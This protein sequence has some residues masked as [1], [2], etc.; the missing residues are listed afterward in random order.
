MARNMSLLEAHSQLL[1][2]N[3]DTFWTISKLPARK[4]S[5][6][7]RALLMSD[8]G[9]GDFPRNLL[10]LGCQRLTQ[11]MVVWFCMQHSSE[12]FPL[13]C[14]CM[15]EAKKCSVGSSRL[16]HLVQFAWRLWFRPRQCLSSPW[17]PEP[18]TSTAATASQTVISPARLTSRPKML[19]KSSNLISSLSSTVSWS[20][21]V[22]IL[23]DEDWLAWRCCQFQKH[24]KQKHPGL[25]ILQLG[26]NPL[27]ITSTW[28]WANDIKWS[29]IQIMYY[30]AW[31]TELNTSF[32]ALSCAKS[33][34]TATGWTMYGSPDFL[35]C[36]LC[37]NL[38]CAQMLPILNFIQWITSLY[39]IFILFWNQ[40]TC[41]ICGQ[42]TLQH[43]AQRAPV[44]GHR[45]ASV[46]LE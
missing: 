2:Q 43:K 34:A 38:R 12:Y 11:A 33:S 9:D 31:D 45:E 16:A 20:L 4:F 32:L 14:N 37:A 23:L 10:N 29:Q 22:H 26:S 46:D 36:P 42:E 27:I 13:L 25:D 18:V 35:F 39:S 30:K 7:S 3:V 17:A 19:S 5:A 1:R 6:C 28:T 41:C 8:L 21:M 24:E 15:W 40:P 44:S